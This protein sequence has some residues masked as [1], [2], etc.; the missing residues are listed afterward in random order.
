M[1]R[2][3]AELVQRKPETLRDQYLTKLVRERKLTLAFPK[4]PTHERQ[5]YTTAA[6][7]TA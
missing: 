5:A 6:V 4:T 1:L 7:T 2:T 3:L